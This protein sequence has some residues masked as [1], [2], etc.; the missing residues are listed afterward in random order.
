MPRWQPNYNR[1]FLEDVILV[2]RIKWAI[3]TM[4]PF[5][6][7]GTDGIFSVLLQKG[8]QRLV[9]SLQSIYRASLLLGYIPKAWRTGQVAFIP[10][11][12]KLDYTTA[13]LLG[14]LA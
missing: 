11:P 4:A 6:S 9:Y 10:K 3:S 5:K 13:K 7:P 1:R 8:I 14:Q 2:D 12:G